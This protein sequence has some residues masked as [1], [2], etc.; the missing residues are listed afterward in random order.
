M[1]VGYDRQQSSQRQA[2]YSCCL[3]STIGVSSSNEEGCRCS[4]YICVHEMGVNCLKSNVPF[5]LHVKYI[6]GGTTVD[7]M[8]KMGTKVSRLHAYAKHD[9]IYYL[10]FFSRKR[11]GRF[12][13]D[14]WRVPEICWVTRRPKKPLKVI[15]PFLGE[16][17]QMNFWLGS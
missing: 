7:A 9:E 14:C 4:D 5:Q 12:R 8:F 1:T 13:F 3:R 10:L 2:S 16:I 11:R 6:L 15:A 17:I